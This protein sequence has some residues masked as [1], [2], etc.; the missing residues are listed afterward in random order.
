[1][2]YH[3][4]WYYMEGNVESK[5]KTRSNNTH[6]TDECAEIVAS[7]ISQFGKGFKIPDDEKKA[8]RWRKYN[9]RIR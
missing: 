4:I 8:K 1:M 9:N 2:G 7:K 5:P 6:P 3:I